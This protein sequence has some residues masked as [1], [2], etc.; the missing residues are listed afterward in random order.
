MQRI[1]LMV[2]VIPALAWPSS[3]DQAKR[4]HDRIAGVPPDAGTLTAMAA[5]IDAGD[6]EAAAWTALNA[7]AFYDVTLVNMATPWTNEDH[8]VFEP[9]NDYTA[10][11]VGLVRDGADIR[12]L[13]T[14]NVLYVGDAALGLPPYATDNND[15]YEAL[16][17]APVSLRDALVAVDQTTLSGL[18][19]EAVSGV[20]TSR[21]AARAFFIDGTNRAMLRFTMINHLCRDLEQMKDTTRPPDRIRQDVSRSPGG[22]SRIFL[23]NCIGCHAGMDPLAQAFAYYDFEHDGVAEDAGRLAWNAPGQLDPDTGSRVQG[24]YHIN[25]GNFPSGYSTPDD[26]W[27]NYWREGPNAL[28]GWDESLPGSGQGARSM[29]MELSHS[30][31]FASCQVT[32]VFRTVCLREPS[33]ADDRSQIETMRSHLEASGYDLRTSF[34]DAAVH[35]MGD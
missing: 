4:I 11:F 14:T 12:T 24:K 19:A 1:V 6:P 15:H 27:D 26:H 13:L 9:L 35:C 2:L 20:I 16:Q 28:L 29:A 17:R 31:A 22:D 3:L 30:E 18:P 23:N 34:V 25:T 21:A 10:T 7:P 5:A 33:D 8:D 32:R